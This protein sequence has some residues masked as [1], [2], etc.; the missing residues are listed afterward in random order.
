MNIVSQDFWLRALGMFSTFLTLIPNNYLSLRTYLL[1]YGVPFAF[2]N[3]SFVNKVLPD[4][5]N[6]RIET[7]TSKFSF[8][9]VL[10]YNILTTIILSFSGEVVALFYDGFT[11]I[12]GL[13]LLLLLYSNQPNNFET[14]LNMTA[15]AAI[16]TSAYFWLEKQAPY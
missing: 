10:I 15:I 8:M 4:R 11:F 6:K 9:T 1:V 12:F 13:A 16:V 14:W 2:F 7:I 3:F 5:I